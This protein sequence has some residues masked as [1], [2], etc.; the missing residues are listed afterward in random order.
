MVL[1]SYHR[2]N[3]QIDDKEIASTVYDCN[4][5]AQHSNPF[6]YDEQF[7]LENENEKK[8]WEN[9]WNKDG[10]KIDKSRNIEMVKSNSP[11]LLMNLS[12]F[13]ILYSS[14]LLS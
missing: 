1:F 3:N 9:L 5:A 7:S 11:K 14:I 10:K 4:E 12:W 2:L 8:K 6:H 13:F